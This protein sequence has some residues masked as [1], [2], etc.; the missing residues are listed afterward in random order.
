MC[1]SNLGTIIIKNPTLREQADIN[2]FYAKMYTSLLKEG[3]F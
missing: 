2:S 1:V 3:I